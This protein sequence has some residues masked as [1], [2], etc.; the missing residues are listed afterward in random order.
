MRHIGYCKRDNLC[1][2]NEKAEETAPIDR[3]Y[4]MPTGVVKIKLTQF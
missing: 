2:S 3:V 4:A 1:L